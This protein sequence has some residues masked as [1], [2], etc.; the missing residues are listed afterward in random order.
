MISIRGF[1]SDF[2][3]ISIQ[4]DLSFHPIS[5]HRLSTF[6]PKLAEY[7]DIMPPAGYFPRSIVFSPSLLAG[8]YFPRHSGKGPQGRPR[9]SSSAALGAFFWRRKCE[10]GPRGRTLCFVRRMTSAI[11]RAPTI[12]LRRNSLDTGLAS[13]TNKGTAPALKLH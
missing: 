12:L 4:L 7:V 11:F 9:F 5:I 1:Q 3:P 6:F 8:F 13:R 10:K 2:N